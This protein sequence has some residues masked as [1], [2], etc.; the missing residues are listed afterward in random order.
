MIYDTKTIALYVIQITFPEDEEDGATFNF[1]L[2]VKPG[3][4]HQAT[5]KVNAR[6]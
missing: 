2:E 3:R 4:E 6:Q 1:R 5:I